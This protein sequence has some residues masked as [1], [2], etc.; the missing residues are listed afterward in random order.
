MA[1]YAQA[2]AVVARALQGRHPVFAS[3]F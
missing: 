3:W 2:R 1:D